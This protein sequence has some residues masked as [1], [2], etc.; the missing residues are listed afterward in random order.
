[1]KAL[2]FLQ[3]LHLIAIV[4]TASI[5]AP[6]TALA[7]HRL[8]D[9]RV[10][11]SSK[12]PRRLLSSLCS[13]LNRHPLT[14][15]LTTPPFALF[16]LTSQ[17]IRTLN[18]V[19]Q[20]AHDDPSVDTWWWYLATLDYRAAPQRKPD[21]TGQ[22]GTPTPVDPSFSSPFVGKGL[23]EVAKWLRGKPQNVDLDSRYFGVLD[24]QAGK[25]GKVAICRLND[26]KTEKEPAWCI[27]RD[28][29]ESTL[30]L[31]GLPSDLDWNELVE[32]G[33]YTLEL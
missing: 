28:A 20:E 17:S 3:A 30:F 9:P 11:S 21:G 22:I 27:L 1:M 2:F 5:R 18:T 19:L 25:S 15:M 14:R 32:I 31:A 29:D 8:C 13:F 10:L 26:P 7:Y 12:N 6:D 24:K 4:A 16:V 33:R 23:E